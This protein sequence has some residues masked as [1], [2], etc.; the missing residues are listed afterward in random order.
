MKPTRMYPLWSIFNAHAPQL[1]W[2]DGRNRQKDD[3]YE[4]LSE[5]VEGGPGAGAASPKEPT[6]ADS[7]QELS[8]NIDRS[9][10]LSSDA[11]SLAG[12]ALR[13][14]VTA[15]AWVVWKALR[16]HLGWPVARHPRLDLLHGAV[17]A[18]AFHRKRKVPAAL[19][20]ILVIVG[21][22]GAIIAIF[23]TMAPTISS[24]AQDLYT[25]AQRGVDQVLNWIENGLRGIDT[26]QIDDALSSAAIS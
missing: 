1:F 22:F 10:I 12:W 17:A 7:A 8:E 20:V 14:I 3:M 9:V 6:P 23:A 24:Q 13:L 2:H 25:Q 15:A 16:I 21:F 19:A 18:G 5:A 4:S 26:T 11:R